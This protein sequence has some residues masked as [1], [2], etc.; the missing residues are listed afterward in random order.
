MFKALT[1]LISL[2]KKKEDYISYEG[3]FDFYIRPIIQGK[4]PSHTA[5]IT[6]N[7]YKDKKSKN[8]L[9][10]SVKWYREIS[11]KNYPLEDYKGPT[12]KVNPYDIGTIIV[13][14]VK[15]LDKESA[16]KGV[17]IVKFG[18]IK[19]DYALSPILENH[20]LSCEGA[21][22]FSLIKLGDRH[23]NDQSDFS[24]RIYFE[25]TKIT[26]IFSELISGG[27][28]NDFCLD[29]IGTPGIRIKCDPYDNR[30][31]R[32][33]YRKGEEEPITQSILK[34]EKGYVNRFEKSVG[35]SIWEEYSYTGNDDTLKEPSEQRLSVASEKFYMI[36]ETSGGDTTKPEDLTE[37]CLKFESSTLRDCF[38]ISLR[39]MRLIRDVPFNKIVENFNK[40]ISEM[41][42]P[43]NTGKRSPEYIQ[44]CFVLESHKEILRRM[45]RINKSLVLENDS[46]NENVDILENDLEFSAREF[47]N[48]IQQLKKQGESIDRLNCM[49]KKLMGHSKKIDMMRG[50]SSTPLMDKKKKIPQKQINL[51]MKDQ[52][53]LKRLEKQLESRKTLNK[54]LLNEIEKLKKENRKLKEKKRS[55]LDMT[56]NEVR[57]S[58]MERKRVNRSVLDG[59]TEENEYLMG[60]EKNLKLKNENYEKRISEAQ[61]KIQHIEK[62]EEEKEEELIK[63]NEI[64]RKRIDCYE[65]IIIEMTDV[66][67]KIHQ[68][69]PL[70]EIP[71]INTLVNDIT[72]GDVKEFSDLKMKKLYQYIGFISKRLG[73]IE[74]KVNLLENLDL[75]SQE[76]DQKLKE[77]N[78]KIKEDLENNRSLKE[79]EEEKNL[80]IK[81]KMKKFQNEIKEIIQERK[82]HKYE[83][84][85]YQEKIELMEAKI[86][87]LEMKN[88]EMKEKKRKHQE[89]H[90]Y[91]KESNQSFSLSDED[92]VVEDVL[93]KAS[94]EDDDEE[95]EVE[96]QQNKPIKNEIMIDESNPFF[97]VMEIE[98]LQNEK[99]VKKEEV[100]M[101]NPFA[102]AFA[103]EENEEVNFMKKDK[104]ENNLVKKE[105]LK[106]DYNPFNPFFEPEIEENKEENVIKKEEDGKG[107]DSNAGNDNAEGVEDLSLSL[108]DEGF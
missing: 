46:L 91:K 82:K 51:S 48:L 7:C 39:M 95:N 31:L 72:N 34:D 4:L 74:N 9:Y 16:F 5:V 20:F 29:V 93:N 11:G 26:L 99:I 55:V 69:F 76:N 27:D 101:F 68:G 35:S 41:W 84:M 79:K 53:K 80:E 105:T 22:Q 59:V 77:E 43:S 28:F 1:K 94:K 90:R 64:F 21:F 104:E 92:E 37:A 6:I 49:K 67:S 23:I 25:R 106:D 32:I 38:L 75:N 40:I 17:A 52:K 108:S 98:D 30:I 3:N 62:Y 60:L 24:N 8:P 47:T 14:A 96:I 78:N 103:E 50:R 54:M 70:E 33:Y 10:F 36:L 44:E 57:P 12:Y 56:L 18:P 58:R 100:D 81:K 107:V 71:K 65:D 63:E 42:Y 102:D 83:G 13:A 61:V 66:V 97:E 85:T 19:L 87:K 86:K 15:P 73:D 2:S 45:L 89:S 88:S